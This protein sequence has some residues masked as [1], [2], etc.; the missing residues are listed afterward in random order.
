MPWEETDVM[1][2]R[3]K[4]V[5]QALGKRVNFTQLCAG[6]GVSRPTGYRWR[7]R[8][9]EVGSFA[10]LAEKSRRP[11]CSPGRTPAEVEARVVT[12]RRRYGWGARKLRVVLLDEG[13]D[14][15]VW[16][17]NRIIARNA[18][19][20]E[21]AS[22]RPATGRFERELPNELWQMDFKGEYP[23][24][25]G[26]CYP[27]SLLDDHSRY[28]VG[29]Y[30]LSNQRGKGVHRCVVE[31]F[32]RYGVP[33]AMLV[34]HGTPWWSTTNGHGLTWV[35]V[36]LIKQGIHLYVSGVRHPQTQGKVERFHRTLAEGGPSPGETGVPGGLGA[37]LRGVL[38]GV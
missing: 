1:D 21:A 16:T 32:R 17:I 23:V 8:Y 34:D 25:R 6:F 7:E 5:A 11:H 9:R 18:L 4:F 28:A 14:V 10:L 22:H 26:Y 38:C 30:G 2:Q 27:L 31:T 29:L 36:A 24:G 20:A 35:S 33:Q 12:A 3:V 15:K 37:V 19:I 13:L